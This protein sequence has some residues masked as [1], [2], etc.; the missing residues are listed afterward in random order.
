MEVPE[1]KAE[2]VAAADKQVDKFEAAYRRGLMTDRKR[3]RQ[4]HQD[5][6]GRN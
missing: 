6:E 1:E 3:L 4:N 5:L 2:I